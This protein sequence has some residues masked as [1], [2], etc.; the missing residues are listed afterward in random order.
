[1]KKLF[2]CHFTRQDAEVTA[3][4]E[5]LH[6]RGVPLWLDHEGGFV[7]GDNVQA[8][9]RRVIGD[10]DE[11]FGLLLYATPEAL[12]RDFINRIELHEAILRKK[13]DDRFLLLAVPHRMSFERL[14]QL[15]LEKLGENLTLFKSQGIRD[16]DTEG[17]Q[18]LP[19]RPQFAEIANE[20]LRHCLK[21]RRQADDQDEV[22]GLNFCTRD[23][24]PPS[25]DDALD[26]DAT[27]LFG[28]A[29]PPAEAWSRLVAGL[30]DIKKELRA[31]TAVPRLRIRG[32]KHLTAAFLIGRVFPPPTVR[33]I[34]TQQ[35][36]ELWSTACPAAGQPFDIKVNDGDASS[37]AMFVEITATD[38]SVRDGVRDFMQKSKLT[39][40]VS[41]RIEPNGGPRRGAVT[42]NATA[43]AMA[44]QVRAAIADGLSAYG[45]KEI[46]LFTAVPQGLAT[47]IGH[48]LNATVPIQLYEHDG[49]S[50]I[51][52][53][54]LIHS[55]LS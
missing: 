24:L 49:Q 19:L 16:K 21:A 55:E 47:L 48:H 32:S 45:A 7:F 36:P 31:S 33:E 26:I 25:P 39:P 35:G 1:M 54:R 2:L 6:L 4:A 52:S 40:F 43:C 29:A 42:D 15:T 41:L 34:L 18:F 44:L 5:E 37:E 17:I 46:H 14:A 50:Y 30:R 3:L 53:L 11:T 20:V 10:S 13:K 9:A 28:A 27:R 22:I 8:E 12:T 38:K 23:R 51:P